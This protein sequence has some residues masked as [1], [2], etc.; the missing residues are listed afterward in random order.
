MKSDFRAALSRWTEV[1]GPQG[2]ESTP[3]GS[4]RYSR[5]TL[6]YGNVPLGVL[7]P[8]TTAQVQTVVRIAQETGIALYPI[9]R[10][11][12]WGYGDAC[13]VK[14]NQFL[15]DLSRMD[16]ILEVSPDLGYAVIQPGVTQKQLVEHLERNHPDLMLDCTGSGPEASIVGNTLERGFGHTPYGDHFLYSCGMEV[17]LGDGRI[18]NTGFGHYNNARASHVF[19]WGIGPYLDGLFT[20]SNLGIVTKM[21]I[22]LMP[23]PECVKMFFLSVPDEEKLPAITDALRPLRL[24]GILKNIVHIGNDLRVISSFQRYPWDRTGGQTPLPA[25]LRR[26]LRKEAKIG[27]WNISGA[28]YGT[29]GQV[30]IYQGIIK[31]RLRRLGRVR[32]AGKNTVA[33]AGWMGNLIDR[34]GLGKDLLVKI[35]SLEKVYGLLNGRPTEAFMY[36]TLW[37]IPADQKTT[38]LDPLDNKAGLIWISPILPSTGEAAR[39]LMNIV[40]PVFHKYSFDPLVTISLITERAMVSV[41]SICYDKHSPS[42]SQKALD[43]YAELFDS[44]LSAG[45]VPYRSSTHSMHKLAQSSET[46]WD[47][48]SQ[49]KQVLDPDGIIA[50]GRYQPQEHL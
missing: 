26:E 22:W 42:E 35:R 2:V 38:S 3:S 17:V 5:T 47:V 15:V 6:P 16:R 20:Q 50:P 43:C 36:G 23:R 30:R 12:N 39:E 7:Y 29:P 49:I 33:M 18:L 34:L 45:F 32:F 28:I 37:R 41:M 27:A 31:K 40:N 48:S 13:P 24:Q 21:G 14:E 1:L 8:G 11:K 25:E 19:K 4:K 10:G 9:S 44:L 46:F